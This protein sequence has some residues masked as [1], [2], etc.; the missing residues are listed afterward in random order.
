M[1][2]FIR[3]VLAH[4]LADFP[5]QFDAIYRFKIKKAGGQILHGGIF[6]LLALLLSWPYLN[7]PL[8]WGIICFLG[9]THVIID[10]TKVLYLDKRSDNIWTF[11]LDQLLHLAVIGSV[12]LIKPAFLPTPKEPPTNL[13]ALYFNDLFILSFIGYIVTTFAADALLDSL[14]KT[15]QSYML[16]FRE[17]YYGIIERAIITSLVIL[18][19]YYWLLILP[20]LLIRL[21]SSRASKAYPHII[22]S[23]LLA[24]VVGLI[25]KALL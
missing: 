20:I 3:L 13:L 10:R 9:L 22:L 18:R 14:K 8:V 2:L 4:L 6:T 11:C 7:L 25:L 15:L 12:F 5:F 21:T 1:F 23:T 19:G 17:K 16:P 24:V